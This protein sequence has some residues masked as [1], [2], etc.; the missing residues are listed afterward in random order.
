MGE[1]MIGL[2]TDPETGRLIST[3]SMLKTFRRCP[4][5]TEYKYVERLKPKTQGRPLRLGTWMHKLEEVHGKGGNWKKA[6][7]NLKREWLKLFEEERAEIGDLPGDTERLMRSYLWHYQD[8]PWKIL[9][10]EFVLEC[11]LP[12]G[13]IFRDFSSATRAA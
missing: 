11:E 1:T 12:D 3:H 2:Y 9:D 4:K 8:C 5:Q 13:S 6:Q 7:K 10:A